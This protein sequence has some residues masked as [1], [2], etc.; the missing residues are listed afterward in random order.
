M[1]GLTGV[2]GDIQKEDRVFFKNLLAVSTLRGLDSTGI[3]AINEKGQVDILKKAIPAYDL[4]N[5]RK[6][7][8]IVQWDSQVLIGHTR[9]A[10]VGRVNAA[11][12]HPFDTG[13]LVGA[14]NGT[15]TGWHSLPNS[16]DYDVDSE[17]MLNSICQI[18][19]D[20]TLGKIGGAYAITV[21]NSEDHSLEMI[22][23][24]ERPLYVAYKE[25]G[26]VM[27][28]ASESWM[29][30]ALSE[31]C[32]V[33]L[34]KRIFQ[35][36]ENVLLTWKLPDKKFTLKFPD[37]VT[38]RIDIPEKKVYTPVTYQDR[39]SGTG[40]D[41]K[42]QKRGNVV[43]IQDK[44]FNPQH[45]INA[46]LLGKWLDFVP[47]EKIISPQGLMYLEGVTA[48]APYT[49]VRVYVHPHEVQKYLN[50]E[51]HVSGQVC[52]YYA[53]YSRKGV[54]EEPYYVMNPNTL[55][56]VP[57]IVNTLTNGPSGSLVSLWRF[58]ELTKDGCGNCSQELSPDDEIEWFGDSP[59]CENC[60]DIVTKLHGT[61]KGA[62]RC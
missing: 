9:A 54:K 42:A 29:L 25:N 16:K 58:K 50:L 19:W 17:C 12:A 55:K 34:G 47:L 46:G 57:R 18:G 56:I 10:T 49:N 37:A 52:A 5:E 27:Y 28:W 6:F 51:E 26:S 44:R 38:R 30:K 60:V 53:G 43:V 8:Q 24:D 39:R 23:N 1:C 36:K 2:A 21:Y 35:P 48:V 59:V 40:V 4:L 3:A 7:D 15:L 20:E 33:K 11:T 13:R 32:G 22:R 61:P 45:S 41:G 31:R 14:H 62:P